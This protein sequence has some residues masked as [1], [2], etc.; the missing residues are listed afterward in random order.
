MKKL[1]GMFVVLFLT[2][3]AMA[4]YEVGEEIFLELSDGEHPLKCEEVLPKEG[5]QCC[6]SEDDLINLCYIGELTHTFVVVN[7]KK[8]PVHI[9]QSEDMKAQVDETIE[10]QNGRSIWFVKS[11]YEEK[12]NGGKVIEYLRTTR[13]GKGSIEMFRSYDPKD[14]KNAELNEKKE[15]M[16]LF[17]QEDVNRFCEAQWP[18]AIPGRTDPP[19]LK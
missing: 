1:L 3:P 11:K 5:G 12:F 2:A 15:E 16:A 7:G 17:I 8:V 13:L 9:F 4:W 19:F 10:C 6:K 18:E 14:E